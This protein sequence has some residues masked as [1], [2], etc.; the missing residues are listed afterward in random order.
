MITTSK[1]LLKAASSVLRLTTHTHASSLFDSSQKSRQVEQALAL[2]VELRDARDSGT[3][4]REATHIV[5]G[6]HAHA[7]SASRMMGL[8]NFQEG[9][10]RLSAP[11]GFLPL[12]LS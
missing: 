7:S 11:Q 2:T 1:V 3:V 5:L 4:S 12:V 9:N 8:D 6:S 10:F